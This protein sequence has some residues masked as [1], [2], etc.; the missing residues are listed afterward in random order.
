VQEQ[1][2]V[3]KEIEKLREAIRYHDWRYYVLANPE[4]SDKEYDDLVKKLEDLEKRYPQFITHDSPT[5][6][7]SGGLLEGF[8]TV[9]HKVKMLSLDNTYSI[10]ELKEWEDKIKRMLKRKVTLDYTA[11]LKIDGVSC[12]LTYQKGLFSLGST[13]GDGQVGE[14]ITQNLRTVRS[15]PLK[16]LGKDLPEIVEVR[17]EIYMDK[18][19][20]EKINRERIKSGDPPFANPRNAA[21]GSLKLLDPNLVKGRNLKCFIHSFGWAKGYTFR[22][23]LE[24]IEKIKSWGLR[25]N[26]HT[27]F[28]K[29]LREVIDYCQRW[30]EKRDTL[31]YEVDGVVIKVN[32]F[33]FREEL[34]STLKS[35]RWAV[36][37]KFPAHQATTKIE[38]VAYQVGRTGIITPVAILKPVECGGVTISRATL[39]N[40]DEVERLDVRVGDTVLVERAGEVIPKIVKVITS[41]RSGKEKKIKVPRR[42]PECGQDITKDKQEE[43]YWYCTNPDCPARIRESL[44]H[45]SSRDALDIE[46][47]GESVVEE[48]VGR[49]LVRSLP[50][51]YKLK[52]EDFLTL[53]LFKEKKANNLYRAI[54]ESKNKGLARFL[55][56]LG[57]RHVGEKAARV[58]ADEFSQIDRFFTL[59]QED[60]ERIPEIGPIM[61][62]SV[63]NFFSRPKTKKMINEFKKLGLKL[64][65]VR[66]VKKQILSGKRFVF[67]GELASFSRS[68]ACRL[69]E[70][71]GGSWSSSVSKNIDF[72]VVGKNPGSK[73][74][75]AKKLGIKIIN[76]EDFKKLIGKR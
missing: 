40:F 59:K 21:S 69:V 30:Q 41:K 1:E 13:R 73:Y 31:D 34:G 55:Y 37:Y 67:T 48:L 12:S 33:S 22:S 62:D 24:F 3:K 26:P 39:H 16:L 2:L 50:D 72:V 27:S 46:G 64:E 35:P 5:Q 76:E 36:A 49:R 44:L 25:V 61:A 6:R 4:I 52:R 66:R 7:V 10:E 63:I 65:E 19:D 14:D 71:L 38:K 56:G 11:E 68:E 32:S 15:I 58:L 23:Q 51:I 70:E 74:E 75:K 20:F 28:C 9:T 57:I 60:L 18:N 54:Q 43:V 29:D 53:P 45:F 17:G 8:P 42:C 47:M